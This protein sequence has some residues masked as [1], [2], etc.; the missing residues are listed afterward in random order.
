MA[1]RHVGVGINWIYFWQ[2]YTMD[3][4]KNTG[5]TFSSSRILVF[6]GRENDE[7]V[8]ELAYGKL[9]LVGGDQP[10]I[11]LTSAHT[12]QPEKQ[13]LHIFG[14]SHI[15]HNSPRNWEICKNGNIQPT[16]L[17]YGKT[18]WM[19]GD[20]PDTYLTST[21]T[22]L[23]EKFTPNIFWQP[24]LTYRSLQRWTNGQISKRP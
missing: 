21:Q 12:P 23:Q 5:W 6:S 3:Y 1:H 8:R 4:R 15:R 17:A 11:L 7:I 18:F 14:Q 22:G 13:I 19:S 24:H 20:Q 16:Y 2:C 9:S 10:N